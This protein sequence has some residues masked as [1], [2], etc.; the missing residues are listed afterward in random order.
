LL[1]QNLHAGFSHLK[2]S[3]H[4]GSQVLALGEKA[5]HKTNLATNK[6]NPTSKENGEVM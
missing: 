2:P 1:N 5:T 6:T 3:Y 4:Y